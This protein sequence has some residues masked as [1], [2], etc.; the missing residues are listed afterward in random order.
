MMNTINEM[1]GMMNMMGTGMMLG[2]G[3]FCLLLL[4]LL[5]LAIGALIKYLFSDKP[6]P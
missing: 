5:V 2:M 4:L 6:K 3:L 1:G